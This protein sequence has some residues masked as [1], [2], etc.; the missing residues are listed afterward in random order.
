MV[1]GVSSQLAPHPVPP[2]EHP[3]GPAHM[4]VSAQMASGQSSASLATS[5]VASADGVSRLQQLSPSQRRAQSS[6]LFAAVATATQLQPKVISGSGTLTV[7][8][9]WLVHTYQQ[10]RQ[11]KPVCA[12]VAC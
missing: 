12:E 4:T 11:F 5:E 9:S 3:P 8:T 10:F 1:Q 7:T 6:A 2:Q